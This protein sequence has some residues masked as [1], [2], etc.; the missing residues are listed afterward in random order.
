M[1]WVGRLAGGLAMCCAL[2]LAQAAAAQTWTSA[3]LTTYYQYDD[4]RRVTMKIGPDPD[5]AGT[6]KP[7]RVEKYEYDDDGRLIHKRI[8]T[9]NT[10]TGGDFVADESLTVTYAYDGVGNRTQE[11]SA[12][13]VTQ[14]SFDEDDRVACSA[15][16]MSAAAIANPP[17]NVCALSGGDV[18]I[19]GPDR[20]SRNTYDEAGQLTKVERGVGSELIQPSNGG[21]SQSFVEDTTYTLNGKVETR[22]DAN[23]NLSTYVYDGFDRVVELRFP[24]RLRPQDR[25][26]ATSNASDRELYGYDKN[27]NRTNLT[28]RGGQAFVFTYDALNREILKDGPG[29]AGD[30]TT[31]Y[32]LLGKVLSVS[33]TGS[34]VT[35]V[36][37]KAGRRTSETTD[38]PGGALKISSR[39]DAAGNRTHVIFGEDSDSV[40]AVYGYNADG[41]L[42]TIT[43]AAAGA[44]ETFG[45]DDVGRPKSASSGNGVTTGY[46]FRAADGLLDWI[47][48]DGFAASASIHE[49]FTYN[50]AGQL[51]SRTQSNPNLVWTGQP[52][53]TTSYSYNGLNQNNAVAS[54]G[55]GCLDPVA[56][57]DCNGN[58]LV[59]VDAATNATRRFSY[60]AENRLTQVVKTTGSSSTTLAL[61]YDP[62][63]RLLTTSANGTV[64]RFLY[65]GSRLVAEYDPSGS[66]L[67]RYLHGIGT[68]SP[69]VWF[70]GADSFSPRYLHVDRQGS[71]EAYSLSDKS[72]V[73]YAYGPYG[74]VQ[75]W[76]GSRFRYTGQIALPEVELYY[77]KARIY[78]PQNGRFLQ[79][80]PIGYKDNLN[81]YGYVSGDPLNKSD[82]TGMYDRGGWHPP[83]DIKDF[84][85][86][87]AGSE[88]A[89]EGAQLL[90][91]ILRFAKL[92]A[93]P[94][95]FL[96]EMATPGNAH[97][98]LPRDRRYLYRALSAEDL[99]NLRT[100]GAIFPKAP[101]SNASPDGH[102]LGFETDYISTSKSVDRTIYNAA[103]YQN[104]TGTIAVIDR[105]ALEG[106]TLDLTV[107]GTL[108]NPDAQDLAWRES[109][110]LVRGPI[111]W[112]AIKTIS[113]KEDR[114]WGSP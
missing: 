57:Y 32:D 44:I 74:E 85:K 48:H 20:I 25:K 61:S 92:G 75:T 55:G 84:A 56:G 22:Q 14:Y 2:V 26:T 107:P 35:S 43:D 3:D 24:A 41:T 7:R 93:A 8:G 12:Y 28:K 39:Y 114:D 49:D 88:A 11:T 103:A 51:F 58:V 110:V 83:D 50:P 64:T 69:V 68:D 99:K 23:D 47:H 81:L 60:D 95:A 53:T 91:R 21:L 82:P 66:R 101:G 4:M 109:E 27:G 37:D 29:T 52:S 111:P 98:E 33:W 36:Y 76:T 1:L 90:P 80:D 15:V 73:T 17:A 6:G 89:R 10:I 94:L 59:D 9:A 67:R 71:V 5:G 70:E 18:S 54:L 46:Q 63:G 77:Y 108:K 34:S 112:S 62:L 31:D 13:G 45:Y 87:V 106:R 104:S 72:L 42:K 96:A 65:E 105:D 79:T 97:V 86:G 19:Y 38:G 40:Y 78:D 100:R 113:T 30:V 102:V 16:R